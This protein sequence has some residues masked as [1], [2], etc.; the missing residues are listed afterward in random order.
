MV[1]HGPLRLVG[2]GGSPIW[3]ER[4]AFYS[5]GPKPEAFGKDWIR[6]GGSGCRWRETLK[7]LGAGLMMVG[8]TGGADRMLGCS[9]RI[10]GVILQE[11][12]DPSVGPFI[13][14][15]TTSVFPL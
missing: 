15:W 3:L 5:C 12:H 4:G 14:C 6:N 10:G 13:S 2:S 8:L 7:A 1:G 11:P 9:V